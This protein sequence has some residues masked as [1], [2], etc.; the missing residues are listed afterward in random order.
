MANI[1]LEIE[2]PY[3]GQFVTFTAPCGC[4]SVDNG[5]VINNETYTLVDAKGN[6]KAGVS[7]TW[8]SGAKVSVILDVTNKKAYIQNGIPTASDVGALPVIDAKGSSFD[9]NAILTGGAHLAIYE[10]NSSTLN[11][12]NDVGLTTMSNAK[13]LSFSTGKT[14]GYQI[15]FC[16][17]GRLPYMRRLNN[18]TIYDWSIGYTASDVGALKLYKTLEDFG[19]TDDE[20][21]ETDALANFVKI[22]NV[23]TVKSTFIQQFDSSTKFGKALRAKLK[24]DTGF[25]VGTNYDVIIEKTSSLASHIRVYPLYQSSG[26]MYYAKEFSCMLRTGG[27]SN[28]L[29][30]FVLTRDECNFYSPNNK[31][32]A[33]DIGVTVTSDIPLHFS[34]NENGGLRITYDDRSD[35]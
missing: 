24:T 35:E 17:G 5:L 16:S 12:P 8:V 14:Y 1:K 29:T 33:E 25:D 20:C 13:I 31:P 26:T 2:N 34:I 10:V 7:N 11:T 9:M 27:S 6:I 19:F 18:G 28:V 22:E 23:M 30:P 4:D 32:T 21:S 3:N 15:A